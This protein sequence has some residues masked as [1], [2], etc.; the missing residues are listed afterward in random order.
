ML[1]LTKKLTIGTSCSRRVADLEREN[2]R[3]RGIAR[4]TTS[5]SGDSTSS[6]DDELDVLRAQLA[7]AKRRE[8]EL[9]QRL[10]QAASGKSASDEIKREL[11][12]P[13]LSAC[14][15]MSTSSGASSPLL[16]PRNVVAN[17]KT[18][19]SLGLMVRFSLGSNV[20]SSEA[21]RVILLK[22]GTPLRPALPPLQPLGA[23]SLVFLHPYITKLPRYHH[24]GRSSSLLFLTDR[25]Y[26]PLLRLELGCR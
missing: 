25:R 17:P 14:D 24:M 19:A 10:E 21:N 11:Y 18:G 26:P 3:L 22:P 15:N 13:T 5:G 20:G 23:P 4:G 9:A 8:A 2:A 12:E 1:C 6:A 7:D 16:G